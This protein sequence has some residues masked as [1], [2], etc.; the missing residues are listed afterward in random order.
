MQLPDG[1]VRQPRFASE[2][3]VFV[4][5]Q[6]GEDAAGRP[7]AAGEGWGIETSRP[8]RA[9]ARVARELCHIR[10]WLWAPLALV[11]ASGPAL[12]SVPVAARLFCPFWTRRLPATRGPTRRNAAVTDSVDA[13]AFR[14]RC[15]EAQAR[16]GGQRRS[17]GR[18]NS[19]LELR[20]GS[21]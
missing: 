21:R 10:V 5:R 6:H 15:H 1:F 9:R 17:C 2:N 16:S 20:V 11:L 4:L 14:K 18:S 13:R 7:R 3:L 8:W 19:G 12:P